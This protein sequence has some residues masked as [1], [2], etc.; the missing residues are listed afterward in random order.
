MISV[1]IAYWDGHPVSVHFNRETAIAVGGDVEEHFVK[2]AEIDYPV[3]E[4]IRKDQLCANCYNYVDPEMCWCGEVRSEHLAKHTFVPMGCDCHKGKN[5]KTGLLFDRSF[6]RLC[7]YFGHRS[8]YTGGQ[9]HPRLYHR[10]GHHDRYQTRSGTPPM[11][12]CIFC[13]YNLF[14]ETEVIDP[15]VLDGCIYLDKADATQCLH[16]GEYYFTNDALEEREARLEKQLQNAVGA[17]AREFLRKRKKFRERYSTL[18][19]TS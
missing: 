3:K 6:T 13:R 18:E 10:H 17:E 15:V 2:P 11:K 8:H 1:Y 14:M 7:G 19:P 5:E 16:C 12:S 9:S 4:L